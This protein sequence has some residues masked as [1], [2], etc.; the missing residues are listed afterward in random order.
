M[1]TSEDAEL[2]ERALVDQ[3]RQALARGELFFG[4]LF[5][6]L[7]LAPAQLDALAARVEVLDEGAQQRGAL[8]RGHQRPLHCGSRFWKNAVTPSTMS[9]VDSASVSCA[10]R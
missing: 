3:Q 2:R 10:R 6:D 7:G 4:V 8:P 1:R 5:G 9:S